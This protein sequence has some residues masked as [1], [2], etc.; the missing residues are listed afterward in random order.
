M[1]KSAT[2]ELASTGGRALLSP[3]KAVRISVV[4]KAVRVMD[5]LMPAAKHREAMIGD[6]LGKRFE[7]PLP[8]A[9]PAVKKGKINPP[10]N[11]AATVKEIAII[12]ATPRIMAVQ[13]EFI[14]KPIKPPVG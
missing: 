9:A 1:T 14:S 11:P 4:A 2:I 7:S 12:F 13:N 8:K 6:K 3:D 10:R 5:T